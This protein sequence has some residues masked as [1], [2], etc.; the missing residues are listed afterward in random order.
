MLAIAL[1]TPLI[2]AYAF[3]STH[4]RT[5]LLHEPPG[6][7]R[8]QLRV[9]QVG[10]QLQRRARPGAPGASTPPPQC[11]VAFLQPLATA[12][13]PWPA[14]VLFAHAKNTQ[15]RL[16]GAVRVVT[17]V[18]LNCIALLAAPLAGAPAVITNTPSPPAG[19]SCSCCCCSYASCPCCCCSYASC[20]CCCCSYSS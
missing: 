14:V 10:G 16:V 19:T 12:P 11:C 17:A 4:T 6:A 15:Q 8:Q 1:D 20:L 5:H 3:T 9:V 7:H 18:L 2:H 13:R